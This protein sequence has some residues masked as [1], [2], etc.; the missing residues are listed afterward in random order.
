LGLKTIG[1][2]GNG[3]TCWNKISKGTNIAWLEDLDP[4][5][6]AALDAVAGGIAE[7][8]PDGTQQA[9]RD[10]QREN[11]A[12]AS[13]DEFDQFLFDKELLPA[14]FRGSTRQV[15]ECLA[16][17]GRG[18]MSLEEFR[19]LDHWAARR[20]G[21]TPILDAIVIKKP[22]EVHWSPPPPE[23]PHVPDLKDFRK[24]LEQR[25][26]SPARAWRVALDVKAAG[27][28]SSCEFGMACR[29]MGWKHPHIELWN[30]LVDEGGGTANLRGLDPASC[31]AIDTLVERMLPTYG[32]LETFWIAVLDP[33]G[34]GICSRA[35]WLKAIVREIGLHSHAA[36]L[37]FTA[38]DNIHSG[39]IAF[40]ELSFIEDFIPQHDMEEDMA[41]TM[42]QRTMMSSNSMPDITGSWASSSYEGA[43]GAG[44][45]MRSRASSSTHNLHLGSNQRSSRAMQHRSYANRHM[46]KYRWMGQA[47][48]AHTRSMSEGSAWATLKREVEPKMPTVGGTALSDVFRFTNEFYRE[49]C[50]RLQHHHEMQ[51]GKGQKSPKSA[52]PA[53]SQRSPSSRL[54]SGS[55]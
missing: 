47:A 36:G 45:T 18:L 28:L 9:W 31:T 16:L 14:D 23:P 44:S 35:E 11:A 26:G 12:R 5:L 37:I 33:D 51:A 13:A 53:S 22:P 10:L 3:K 21:Y 6:G 38:L 2:S 54:M 40:T 42:D 7:R 39:W 29:Q 34:D 48:G 8:Y 50:R 46:A 19:F 43:S 30:E 17:S 24:Y 55:R 32:D 4:K 27:S 25:F 20:L 49:G 52:S 15:F 1:F 41:F